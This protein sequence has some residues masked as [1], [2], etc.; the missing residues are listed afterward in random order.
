MFE[1]WVLP[2]LVFRV[3]AQIV[4]AKI[5]TRK[6]S[7]LRVEKM[8]RMIKLWKSQKRFNSPYFLQRLSHNLVTINHQDILRVKHRG[9]HLVDEGVVGEVEHHLVEREARDPTVLYLT[10]STHEEVIQVGHDLVSVL[11]H[12]VLV[13]D[14][15]DDPVNRILY[16]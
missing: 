4:L 9:D 2:S 11:G 10:S 15:R 5:E 16:N 6:P 3:H 14:V 12:G 8:I 1:L 7:V 13:Q